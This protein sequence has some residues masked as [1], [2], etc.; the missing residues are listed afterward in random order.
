MTIPGRGEGMVLFCQINY[1]VTFVKLSIV[2]HRDGS[3]GRF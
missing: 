3:P 2:D 1:G